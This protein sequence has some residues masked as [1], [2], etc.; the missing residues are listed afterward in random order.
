MLSIWVRNWLLVRRAVASPNI[1]QAQAALDECVR[2]TP[3]ESLKSVGSVASSLSWSVTL[4]AMVSDKAQEQPKVGS[5]CC[6][7]IR[8]WFQ[9]FPVQNTAGRL[10]RECVHV[11]KHQAYCD[12]RHVIHMLPD[13]I[14]AHKAIGRDRHFITVWSIRRDLLVS[15]KGTP[16]GRTEHAWDKWSRDRHAVRNSKSGADH[17][18]TDQYINPLNLSSCRHHCGKTSSSTSSTAALSQKPWF[19][20]SLSCDR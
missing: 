18:R 15:I 7:W 9:V 6:R 3:G 8:G 17:S 20:N 19:S 2:N 13:C 12:H 10:E 14:F 11:S 1:S 4:V 16:S 5:V